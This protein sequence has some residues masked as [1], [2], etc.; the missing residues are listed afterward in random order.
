MSFKEILQ[1]EGFNVSRE[2][3]NSL[4]LYQEALLKWQAS[5]NLI[6]QSTVHTLWERHFLDSAQLVKFIW[7]NTQSIADL[8]SGAGFPGMVVALMTNIPT[9]LI[10][11]KQKKSL[12]LREVQKITK[13]PVTVISSRAEDIPPLQVDLVIARAV[14]ELSS[15]LGY[16]YRHLKKEGY[17][18]FLKGR[19]VKEEITKAREKWDFDQKQ[20]SS[21]TDCQASILEIKR[22]ERK[23][24]G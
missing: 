23:R 22:I 13:S 8:G 15:L 20:Y 14:S 21:I 11:S 9:F 5:Y 18:L 19:N 4:N 2:T 12:F 10:E 1:K 17:C 24:E 3:L 6:S 7:P 16:A